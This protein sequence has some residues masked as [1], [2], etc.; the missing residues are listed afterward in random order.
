[1]RALAANSNNVSA[2]CGMGFIEANGSNPQAAA[3]YI[4]KVMKDSYSETLEKLASQKNI[5]LNYKSMRPKVP[6]IFSPEK[7]KVRPCAFQF[8]EV[9]EAI[10]K[11]L[12]VHRVEEDWVRKLQK[13]NTDFSTQTAKMDNN[14]KLQLY[15]GYT[16]N[17]FL[18]KKAR[19][20][21]TQADLYFNDFAMRI[22]PAYNN[23]RQQIAKMQE[24]LKQASKKIRT[25]IPDSYA[26]CQEMKKTLNN[27]LKKTSE[28]TDDFVR[29]NIY[30]FYDYTNQQLYWNKF[31]VTQTM[32]DQKFYQ[33][34]QSLLKTVD[35]YGNIQ[36]LDVAHTIVY[37]C[38][39]QTAA[40][41]PAIGSDE[42]PGNCPFSLKVGLGIGSV[43]SN[44][45]GWTMEGG[46]IVVASLSKNY[47]TGEFSI[48]FGMGGNLQAPFLGG[49]IGAQM[50]VTVGSD[51]IPTDLGLVGNA[52]IE[53]ATGPVVIGEESVNATMSIASGLNI[54]AVHAGQNYNLLSV[55]PKN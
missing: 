2:N 46:E 16:S 1:M 52:G 4:E 38:E 22:A 21:T 32:Y 51:F 53:A 7:Y 9:E 20:M 37:D 31:L 36:A 13:A 45:H 18:A 40:K 30:D 23:L 54:D 43:K 42:N 34:A 6:D 26:A 14:Q 29:L 44:C 55:S 5:Q 12:Q 28:L 25:D 33:Y 27:Y 39:K 47:Q 3:P 50:V 48:G 11:R 19:F 17:T 35:D 15:A 49:S 8:E 10:E 24:D 41:K